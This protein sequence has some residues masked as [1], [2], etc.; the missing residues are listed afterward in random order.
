MTFTS[1]GSVSP[2]LAATCAVCF[3]AIA[4][5]SIRRWL[6][7]KKPYANIPGPEPTSAIG[8]L[9]DL[10][11]PDALGWHFNMPEEFGHVARLKG[12]LLG[13]D[14]LYIT[15]PL[16][17]NAILIRQQAWFPES[18]E[19]AG[20]F[21]VIHCG[22]G[23]ASVQ[24]REHKKQRKYMDVLF[25]AGRVSKLTPMFYQVTRQ[26]EAKLRAALSGKPPGQVVD[27]LDYLTRAALEI[28][29][30]AGIGH[31]FNSFD[32]KSEA[33]DQF[34]GA[35]TSVLPLA[36][37]L[38]LVLP[39]LESWRKMRP[40][41]LRRS[42][43]AI[44]TFP[45]PAAGRF[46]AAVDTMH[47]V[48]VKLYNSRKNAL[49]EGGSAALAET[50][51][52]G[53]DLITSMIQANW[54]ADEADKMSDDIVLANM[55]SIKKAPGEDLDFNELER[56][57]LLDA[58]VREM[59]RIHSPV[60]FVWRQTKKDVVVPLT[61]PIRSTT[62]GEEM[63]QLL[64]KEGTAVYLGLSA[65]NRST[66]IWGADAAEFKPDRWLNRT[67]ESKLPGAYSGMMTFLSGAK[68]CPGKTF[69]LLEMTVLSVLLLSFSFE[70]ISEPIDW[71]M[72]ITLEP[73]VRGH[74]KEG[75]QVPVRVTII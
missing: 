67:H 45:W 70:P 19:F 32:D 11:S 71:R 48:Y 26:L 31:T 30:T 7:A 69:A 36:S 38:F 74:E 5:S 9:L 17:L 75:V 44:A 42:L 4:A 59:L 63:T 29:G 16:A 40:V 52:G 39:F 12:G 64:I 47:P 27:M 58:V 60:T 53:K 37:R 55:S 21:G 49:E 46:R 6:K 72:G 51:A 54:D 50:A 2:L 56:L 15:D 43:A 25:T 68:V 33:F 57:P 20:L 62:T 1:H 65:A 41:W 22:D 13:A 28:I 24:G 8:Y 3:V 34:H 23:V 73:R 14:A 18:T 10:H 66:A 61:Y 35:I